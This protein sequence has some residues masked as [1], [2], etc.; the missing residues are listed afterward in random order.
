MHHDGRYVSATHSEY[1]WDAY[2][3]LQCWSH[4]L[5]WLFCLLWSDVNIFL[6]FLGLDVKKYPR[7]LRLG[8]NDGGIICETNW[9]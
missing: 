8:V 2:N 1:I 6:P 7:L 4:K 3:E 9:K 5:F